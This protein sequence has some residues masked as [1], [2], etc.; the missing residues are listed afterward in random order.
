M[1]SVTRRVGSP[2][3]ASPSVSAVRRRGLGEAWTRRLLWWTGLLIVPVVWE[4]YAMLA[5]SPL[6]SGR[7][8]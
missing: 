4:L 7:S 8:R 3:A 2:G 5:E 1:T 6:T